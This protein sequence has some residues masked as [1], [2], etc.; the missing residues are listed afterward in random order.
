MPSVTDIYN[1]ALRLVGGSRVTSP[2]DGTKNA[3]AANDI[4]AELRDDLLASSPWNFA[5]KRKSLARSSSVPDFGFA[6][7]YPLPSDW[8]RTVSVHGDASGKGPLNF[9][10]E[11]VNGQRAI[12]T[13]ASVCYLRYVFRQTDP[14]MMS[15]NF[16]RSLE[17]ALARDLAVPIANSNTLEDQLARKAERA[18]AKARSVDALGAF[19]ERRPRGSWVSTRGGGNSLGREY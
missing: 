5:T 16:L 10:E 17:L 13:D 19:P 9:R 3:N 7:A 12:V 4:Y 14:N 8:I 18:L 11:V 1:G 15:S 2:T 6:F